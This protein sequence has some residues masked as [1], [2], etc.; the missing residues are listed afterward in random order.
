MNGT[1]TVF[2]TNYWFLNSSHL[3]IRFPYLEN[4]ELYLQGQHTYGLHDQSDHLQKGFSNAQY[5][6]LD[7]KMLFLA[8]YTS[9]YSLP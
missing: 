7:F 5:L 3:F 1:A 4:L 9:A 8:S 6:G 2:K